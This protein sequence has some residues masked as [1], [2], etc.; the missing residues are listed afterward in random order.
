[1]IAPNLGN[2]AKAA[3]RVIKAVAGGNS[4]LADLPTVGV[5]REIC[6]PCDKN[7]RGQCLVCTCSIRLKTLLNTEHCPLDKWK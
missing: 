5:R 6:G 4:V 7:D 2:A 3:G 1:L